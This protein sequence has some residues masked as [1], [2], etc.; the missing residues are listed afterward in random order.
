VPDKSNHIDP[1]NWWPVIM[2]FAQFYG[3]GDRVQP[4]RLAE[5]PEESYRPFVAMSR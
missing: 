1:D 3:L 5:I 4:S 2:S